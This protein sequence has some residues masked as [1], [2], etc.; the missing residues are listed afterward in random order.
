MDG[1][2]AGSWQ[3]VEKLSTDPAVCPDEV[4]RSLATLSRQPA[5]RSVRAGEWSPVLVC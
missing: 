1:G 4:G 3:F 2:R 5:C